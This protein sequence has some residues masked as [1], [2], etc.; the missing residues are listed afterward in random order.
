MICTNCNTELASNS[1]FCRKCGSSVLTDGAGAGTT[2][3]IDTVDP[4]ATNRIITSPMEPGKDSSTGRPEDR[5]SDKFIAKPTTQISHPVTVEPK[6]QQ[7]DS[8]RPVTNIIRAQPKTGRKIVVAIVAILIVAILGFVVYRQFFADKQNAGSA[9]ELEV[10][11]FL[12]DFKGQNA[13]AMARHIIS[14]R[15]ISENSI[16]RVTRLIVDGRLNLADFNLEKSEAN[17]ADFIVH[18][19]GTMKLRSTGQNF[20][21]DLTVRAIG[22]D[23][24]IVPPTMEQVAT[25]GTVNYLIGAFFEEGLLGHLEKIVADPTIAQIQLPD[26]TPP[27]DLK[28]KPPNKPIDPQT[29]KPDPDPKTDPA[30]KDPSKPDPD[31]PASQQPPNNGDPKS[32][33]NQQPGPP[34][35]INRPVEFE[36]IP[37]PEYTPVARMNKIQGIVVVE[38]TF[39][40]DGTVDNPKII[41]GLPGGLEKQAIIAALHIKFRPAMRDGKPVDIT[42]AV[43]FDFNLNDKQ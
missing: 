31:K 40:A 27:A 18:I 1:R 6:I 32:P 24:K 28:S 34:R 7:T 43:R 36:L 33:S 22:N 3:V 12:K 38:A 11:D 10:D 21:D 15:P 30:K 39:H 23:W 5:T 8:Q 2:E 20:V 9:A 17:G 4:V 25:E 19:S 26:P 14:S 41:K 13:R 42:R 37:K 29:K 16:N 35:G